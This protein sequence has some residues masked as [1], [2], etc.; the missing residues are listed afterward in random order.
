[1]TELERA[2]ARDYLEQGEHIAD[3]ILG[4]QA[5]LVSMGHGI[6]RALRALLGARPIS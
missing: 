3:F 4:T 5:A 6:E 2:A 1:M